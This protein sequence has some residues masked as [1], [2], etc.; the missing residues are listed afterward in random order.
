MFESDNI[1]F[2]KTESIAILFELFGKFLEKIVS[3]P[4]D[5]E[6]LSINLE[7]F[8]KIHYDLSQL[9]ILYSQN[10]TELLPKPFIQQ[11][12][13]FSSNSHAY[14]FN[15]FLFRI[16]FFSSKFF[17]NIFQFK[18][19]YQNNAELKPIKLPEPQPQPP[20][21]MLLNHIKNQIP[22][23]SKSNHSF[24]E[25]FKL[26]FQ[27]CSLKIVY[28][29]NQNNPK[30][31]N[32][33]SLNEPKDQ[34]T[35]SKPNN[36]LIEDFKYLFE[37]RKTFSDMIISGKNHQRFYC[38]KAILSARS[39]YFSINCRESRNI[40][41]PEI[42]E[43]IIEQ[44]LKYIYYGEIEINEKNNLDLFKAA[45]KFK[46][47]SLIEITRESVAKSIDSNP[48]SAIKILLTISDAE[49]RNKCLN[50]TLET[51]ENEY[52]MPE[53]FLDLKPDDI[54]ELFNLSVQKNYFT[55]FHKLINFTQQWI[56]K[57][58][59]TSST[60]YLNSNENK[61]IRGVSEEAILTLLENVKFYQIHTSILNFIQKTN[62]FTPKIYQT[63]KLIENKIQ[64]NTSESE[65]YGKL[66]QLKLDQ[67]QE[68]EKEKEEMMMK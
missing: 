10:L 41:F 57:F 3:I 37:H 5:Q 20:S 66:T 11:K 50:A 64:P 16:T 68:K 54:K 12:N 63:I 13:K 59:D 39:P 56:K 65:T 40:P 27:D 24:K 45:F 14:D 25:N 2:E 55:N 38:H 9:F 34:E 62:G 23:K 35:L 31:P 19:N 28:S 53:N 43:E 36:G 44:I 32:P 47:P 21:K 51:I 15:Q 48:Q 33:V 61:I 18:E 58:S 22:K 49:I 67:I 29:E 1:L 8:K 42:N 60:N 17:T 46:I 52:K 30:I 6:N 4:T 26:N 7:Y